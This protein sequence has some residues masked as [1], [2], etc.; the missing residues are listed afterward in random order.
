MLVGA[1]DF[2]MQKDHQTLISG[3]MGGLVEWVHV[4]DS[5]ALAQRSATEFLFDLKEV[6]DPNIALSGGRI[7]PAFYQALVAKDAKEGALKNCHYFWA[8]ERCVPPDSPESNY[9]AAKEYLLGPGSVPEDHIHRIQG[10]LGPEQ[11]SIAARED[12]ARLLGSGTEPADSAS[13]PILD[14]VILGMGEDGH[15]ASL[16]PKHLQDDVDEKEWT[17]YGVEDSPKPPPQ[18]V[19]LSYP[20]LIAAKRV[21][22]MIPGEGKREAFESG[23]KRADNP[24]GRLISLRKK[25]RVYSDFLLS[26]TDFS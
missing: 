23:L 14:L 7:A 4:A 12:L 20:M 25:V 6:S 18:R 24:I 17:F 13:A 15:V 10:E 3:S 9:L 5:E 2:I 8:D 22:I 16:F 21:W 11:A 19:T 1:L 26:K